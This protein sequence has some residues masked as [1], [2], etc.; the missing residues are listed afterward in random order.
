MATKEEIL[1][2]DDL[3]LRE[4]AV[5][6]WGGMVVRL[7]AMSGDV[8]DAYELAAFRER[9]AAKKEA[10][11]VRNPRARML[12]FC[13]VDEKGGRLFGE[14]DVARLGAKSGAALDR[15]YDAAVAQNRYSAA[16]QKDLEK[17]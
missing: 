10:R 4:V 6:E 16:E 2:R 14:E 13:L 3:E 8:R 15:L 7:R 12:V 17:S 1:G 5:P 9:E 11:E